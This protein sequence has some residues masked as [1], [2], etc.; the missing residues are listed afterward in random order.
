MKLHSSISS[1][2]SASGFFRDFI[3]LTASDL[4]SIFAPLVNKVIR[5]IKAQLEAVPACKFI[6]LVG[7]LGQSLY[8]NM[9]VKKAFPH[10][11]DN[12]LCPPG[13]GNAISHGAV[14]FALDPPAD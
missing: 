12:I 4:R 3:E 11:E 2:R 6:F 14:L 10:L 9:R 5:M 13:A 1:S 7:G 8:L